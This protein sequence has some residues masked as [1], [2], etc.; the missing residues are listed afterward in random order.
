MESIIPFKNDI[1]FQLFR[2]AGYDYFKRRYLSLFFKNI[3]YPVANHGKGKI[4]IYAG[5]GHMYLTPMEVLMYHL[6]RKEGY[7]VDY[8]IY[9]QNAPINE[10]ITEAVIK[11]TGKDLFWNKCV[12]DAEH[13]LK[14]SNVKYNFITFPAELDNIIAPVK[15]DLNK[16]ITFKY[17]DIHFGGIVKGVMYR[18]YKSI[19][20]GEDALLRANEFLKTSLANYFQVK[21][22][23]A[24]YTYQYLFFSH[25]IYC[26]WEPVTAYCKK[27]NIPFIC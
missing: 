21:Q 10:I 9:D 16:I 14:T 6:L 15:N 8:Y 12:G 24:A 17:N 19:N 5:I 23:C 3:D 20:F 11:K 25:G 27:N 1:L 4:I 26:T 18:F 22:L 2:K 7:D 13:F